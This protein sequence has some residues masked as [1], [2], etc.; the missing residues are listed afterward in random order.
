MTPLPKTPRHHPHYLLLTAILLLA[1][2]SAPPEELSDPDTGPDH[3]PADVHD[4]DSSPPQDILDIDDEP[5]PFDDL[6]PRPWSSQQQGPFQ[7]GYRYDSFEYT[8]DGEGEPPREIKVSIWYPT[9]DKRGV[10]AR[11]NGA[12]RRDGVFA[13]PEPAIEQPAPVMLFSHGNSSLSAQSYFL[14]EFLTSHGWI[15]V[16][17]D[18]LFNTLSDTEG[19]INYESGFHRPQDI[20]ATLDYV[21]DL[22]DDD[23][24]AGQLSDQIAVSGHSFGGYT[25]L[26]LAG[27]TFQARELL[28]A[29]STGEIQSG[30]CDMFTP[31]RADVFEKGFYDERIRVAIPHTPGGFIAFQQGLADIKIPLL[32]WTAGRDNTLPNHEEGDPIWEHLSDDHDHVRIDVA[33]TGHFTFSN[34]CD[35]LS[36]VPMVR[37]DGCGE[38]FFPPEEVYPLVNAYSLEFLRLHLFGQE[39]SARWFSEDHEPLHENLAFSFK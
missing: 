29:C 5:N 38:D 32:I 19:S 3:P 2:C 27:A 20:S 11:Y 23:P 15:V 30:F 14:S 28:Q 33:N 7:V 4:Q 25:A 17:P 9:L 22:P 35:L 10:T 8:P 24:L 26:A 36:F 37:D 31:E 12:I 6:P 1:G 18:H 21:L 13:E 39:E 34:M 16:A